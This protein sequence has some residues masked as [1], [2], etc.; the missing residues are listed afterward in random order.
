MEVKLFEFFLERGVLGV[1]FILASVFLYLVVKKQIY[2]NSQIMVRIS[3]GMGELSSNM[4]K[5]TESAQTKDKLVMDFLRD[6]R[7]DIIQVR[8]ERDDCLEKLT[9]KMDTHD[10]ASQ[11]GLEEIIGAIKQLKDGQGCTLPTLN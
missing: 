11:K 1:L 2:D 5:I 10:T 7:E 8:K 6:M 3:A 9:D 4:A